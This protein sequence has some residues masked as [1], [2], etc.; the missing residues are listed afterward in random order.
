[1]SIANALIYL[2]NI[3]EAVYARLQQIQSLDF[4]EFS[5]RIKQVSTMDEETLKSVRLLREVSEEI[6][7]S[8]RVFIDNVSVEGADEKIKPTIAALNALA[9]FD[10][11]TIEA[12]DNLKKLDP[13]VASKVVDFINRLDLSKVEALKDDNIDKG[14]KN[15]VRLFSDIIRLMNAAEGGV[16]GVFSPL[17]GYFLG[18]K[19]GAFFTQ[20]VK[21]I[22]REK[23]KVQIQGV[24]DL[25][26]SLALFA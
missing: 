3:D 21:A 15:L 4:S 6:G 25:L 20:L 12:L 10:K 26:N 13:A 11:K 17:K 1:M 22:P 7:D 24:G 9:G 5:N 8:I 18:K 2:G 16:S 14:M 19:I 23:I